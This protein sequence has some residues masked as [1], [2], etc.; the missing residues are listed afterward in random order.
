MNTHLHMYIN[1]YLT[2]CIYIMRI[3]TEFFKLS[4]VKSML[5]N[6]E[7]EKC[8]VM[9]NLMVFYMRNDSLLIGQCTSNLLWAFNRS[10]YNIYIY[11][12]VKSIRKYKKISNTFNSIAII[13]GSLINIYSLNFYFQQT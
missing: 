9:H 8:N 13:I 3:T 6:N 11:I 12:L 2:I 4:K 1:M 10:Q 7:C 5:N